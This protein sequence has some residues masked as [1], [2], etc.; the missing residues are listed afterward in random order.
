M[1][2]KLFLTYFARLRYVPADIKTCRISR[3]VPNGITLNYSFPNL[4]PPKVLLSFYK[5][6][7]IDFSEYSERYLEYVLTSGQ[8]DIL[9]I[10]EK[11]D[12]GENLVLVCYEKNHLCHRFL[13]GSIFEHLGYEVKEL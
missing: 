4:Y 13:L 6:N 12:N 9:N 8:P 7:K 5:S 1:K 2:G 3:T 11:L 10:K